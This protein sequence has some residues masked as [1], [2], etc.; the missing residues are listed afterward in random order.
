MPRL[1]VV[2]GRR[3]IRALERAGF[4]FDRQ[5]GSHVTL[6]HKERR[7]SATVPVHGN[8][9]LPSGT[10]RSILRQAGLTAE[11]FQNLL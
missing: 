8:E 7:R 9:D 1:P 2:S 3:T 5:Q 10:L 4:V 6:R 11:E